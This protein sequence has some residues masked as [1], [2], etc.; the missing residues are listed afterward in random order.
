MAKGNCFSGSEIWYTD[1]TIAVYFTIFIS[2]SLKVKPFLILKGTEFINDTQS[3]YV[4]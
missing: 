3:G 1:I 2:N 4:K